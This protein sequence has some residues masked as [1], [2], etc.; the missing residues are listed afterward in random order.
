MGAALPLGRLMMSIYRWSRDFGAK[1]ARLPILPLPC[2]K[3][4]GR[5]ETIWGTKG[6]ITT[7]IA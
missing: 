7:I 2:Q 1:T 5:D 6:F 4:Q 3:E